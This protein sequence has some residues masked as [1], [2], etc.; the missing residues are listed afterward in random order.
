MAKAS[1]RTF[2]AN[3]GLNYPTSDGEARVE[4]GGK[5]SDLP[6]KSISWLLSGGYITDEKDAQPADATAEATDA[7]GAE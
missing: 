4:A 2:I 6:A 5:V 7:G 3:V 1:N